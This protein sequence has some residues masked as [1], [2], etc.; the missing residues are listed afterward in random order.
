VFTV[1]ANLSQYGAKAGASSTAQDVFRDEMEQTGAMMR[2]A[3]DAGVPLLC[4]SESGF[5]LTPYG[6]WHAREMEIFVEHLGLSPLEAIT[7]CTSTN[8]LALGEQGGVGTIE[9]DRRA[10]IL[11]LDGD[12][13]SDI[14]ILGDKSRFRHLLCRGRPVDLTPV[15]PR[16]PLRSERV[17]PW[18]AVPLTWD[19]VH[20]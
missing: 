12:P 13:T 6:H 19:L 3:Y 4:G 11:V 18:S 16:T 5:S 15:P 9:P 10:D 8:A 7:C 1:L 2:R 14:T 17:A 20:P